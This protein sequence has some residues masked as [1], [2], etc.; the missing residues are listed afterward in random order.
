MSRARFPMRWSLVR[1][2]TDPSGDSRA[3]EVSGHFTVT[4]ALQARDM[5]RR[6]YGAAAPFRL[7]VVPSRWAP[8]RR[9]GAWL[10]IELARRGPQTTRQ[11]KLAGVLPRMVVVAALT[12]LARSGAIAYEV[13]AEAPEVAQILLDAGLIDE[14]SE[15][16]RW[17]LVE[18]AANILA[19]AAVSGGGWEWA[20]TGRGS[21]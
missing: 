12:D 14:S 19:A 8:R 15:I 5:R 21:I 3:V 1:M 9:I 2:Y 6:T 4:A 10:A 11:L 18:D 17:T 16:G 13:P 20:V 7:R